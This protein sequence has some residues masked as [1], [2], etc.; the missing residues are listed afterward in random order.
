MGLDPMIILKA[1]M[2]NKNRY[3]DKWICGLRSPFERTFSKQNKRARYRG[4]V[5]NQGAEFMFAA[6]Y[7]LRH[8]IVLDKE[9][10]KLCV[11]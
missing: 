6:A 8:A 1:N 11:A 9:R 4:V 7:N 5:K 3:L 2:K 10:R